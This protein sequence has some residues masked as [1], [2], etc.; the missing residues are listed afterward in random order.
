MND[1]LS[2][3]EAENL[4]MYDNEVGAQCL[5]GGV[6]RM[7]ANIATAQAA[8]VEASKR[9]ARDRGRAAPRMSLAKAVVKAKRE[10]QLAELSID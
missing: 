9:T 5:Y 4:M 8:Y 6:D 7:R 2:W 10:A 1:G 3:S